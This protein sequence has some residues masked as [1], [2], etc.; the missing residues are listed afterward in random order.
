MSEEFGFNGSIESEQQTRAPATASVY[1]CR[2]P[3]KGILLNVAVT[4]A[5]NALYNDAST[6]SA[7]DGMF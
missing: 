7:G 3:S 4:L 2:N 1:S 6:C 5:L